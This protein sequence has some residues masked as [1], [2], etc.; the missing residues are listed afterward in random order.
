MSPASPPGFRLNPALDVEAAA[1]GFAATGIASIPDI[2]AP[3][4][5][6]ALHAMLRSRQDWRQVIGG[7]DKL[8]ELD[9]A[10]L[11]ALS[12]EQRAALDQAV[13]AGARNGFQYRYETL[14]VPD[15]DAG[16]E[17][18]ED[19]LVAF[20]GWWSS[21]EVLDLLR[22]VT[23]HADIA[24][25]DMQ[26]TAYSP[27]DFLTAHDDDVAGKHRLAAYVLNLTPRW[28]TEWGGLLAFHKEGS[29]EVTALTPA[30]NRLNLFA[31]PRRHSVTEVTRAAAYRRYSLTG[32]LRRR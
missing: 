4:T 5:A 17:A 31:V 26:A 21:E 23:G 30:F 2:L 27:G 20:A 1:A 24:F 10:A 13:Y 25:A 32:W 12:A 14:R 9:R 15:E 11:A 22:R 28:R 29:A 19:P 18:S 3:E 6:A 16:R 8:Y 7:E